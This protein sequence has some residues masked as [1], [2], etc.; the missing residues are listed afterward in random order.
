MSFKKEN[1]PDPLARTSGS[2]SHYMTK[3]LYFGLSCKAYL[4]MYENQSPN[5]KLCCEDCGRTMH[6]HG[7]YIRSVTTKREM[8]SIPIYRHYCPGC[9]KT[10]SLLPDFLVPWARYATWLRE[11]AV[12][13]RQQGLPFREVMANTANTEVGYSRSTL[14]RW[15]KRFIL[16]AADAANFLAREIAA[17]GVEMDLLGM[18][19]NK[20]TPTPIHTLAWLGKLCRIYCPASL[21]R[22]GD[23]VF[24]N[25]RMPFAAQL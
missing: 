14:K 22:R 21:W 1:A 18:Y 12:K 20:V 6:K 24:L 7:Q 19:P 25:T 4:R 3:V 17:S 5:I 13:R 10:V 2:I 8:I 23:W 16:R 11:A 9:G 15:W